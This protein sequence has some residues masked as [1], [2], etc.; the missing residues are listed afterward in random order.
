[1]SARDPHVSLVIA[2]NGPDR[3]KLEALARDLELKN[4][5]FLGF[6]EEKEKIQYLRKADLFC[7]P[8][9]Y[10]E[11]FGI[12][13]LEAMATGTVTVAGDNPGYE[14]VM[15]GL[16]ALSLVN[17]K[18]HAEFARRMEMLLGEPELRRL[19]RQWATEQL[20]QYSY[21]AIV[22]QYEAVYEMALEKHALGEE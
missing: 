13:L 15:K 1:M 20:P 14:S 2:G 7:S 10:G 4:V 16:G 19:W 5:T 21:T 6:I 17:P 9:L 18:H 11:S 8:A 3:E 12:V 22:D